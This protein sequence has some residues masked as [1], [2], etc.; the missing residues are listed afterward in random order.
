MPQN[1]FCATFISMKY[2]GIDYGTKRI[3]IAISD[4][5]GSIAFPKKII[6]QNQEPNGVKILTEILDMIRSEEVKTIV[7][8]NS[9]DGAGER[10]A[11]ME[12][13]D[14]FVEQLHTL[15]GLPVLLHDERFSSVMARAMDFGKSHTVANPRRNEHRPDHIDDKAAAVMLQRYLDQH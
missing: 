13:V 4:E 5:S 8:G 6:V 12:D 10:N 7:V 3:G 1:L 15:S 11:I 2:L 9:L 14:V